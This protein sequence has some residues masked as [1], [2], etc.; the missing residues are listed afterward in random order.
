[1]EFKL[2]SIDDGHFILC[3]K[4]IK[5]IIIPFFFRGKITDLTNEIAKLNKDINNFNQE[6]ASYLS[7]EKRCAAWS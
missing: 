5:F 4:H 7:Y 2:M 3:A 1:M 6:N